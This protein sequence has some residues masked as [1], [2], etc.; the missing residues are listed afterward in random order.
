MPVSGKFAVLPVVTQVPNVSSTGA[1]ACPGIA[2][3]GAASAS[4]RA[5]R[6]QAAQRLGRRGARGYVVAP[7]AL[8]MPWSSAIGKSHEGTSP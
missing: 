8:G 1:L 5:A 2:S 4:A 6:S 7:S 3:A